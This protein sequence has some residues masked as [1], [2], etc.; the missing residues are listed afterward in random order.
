MK[1]LAKSFSQYITHWMTTLPATLVIA[2]LLTLFHAIV[3]VN[4]SAQKLVT[5]L[6]SKVTL[7]F[8]IR[9][10][11]DPFEISNFIRQLE[12]E[13]D[14]ISKVNY[15]S[16]QD[17]LALLDEAFSLDTALIEKYNVELPAS[18]VIT[19]TNTEAIDQISAKIKNLGGNLLHATKNNDTSTTQTTNDLKDFLLKLEGATTR[20]LSFFLLL[21]GVGAILLI[22]STMHLTLT[23]R[24]KE[25]TIM[26]FVG[27]DAG[28]IMKPFILEGLLIG[29]SAFL[30]NLI[31]I[32]ILPFGDFTSVVARNALIAE[33]LLS[34]ALTTLV[35]YITTARFLR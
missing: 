12:E 26:H 8:Y 22:A 32:A 30:L 24:S 31:F 1:I 10:K 9:E 29:M 5:S 34:C 20:T 21:F 11:S 6:E 17:A 35:S 13:K 3:L 18:I 33:V 2:I 7:T 16:P 23:H 19:P 27:A 14:I 28:K 4:N 25:V 15:T